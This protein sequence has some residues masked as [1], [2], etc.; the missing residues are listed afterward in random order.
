VTPIRME[1]P[2]VDPGLVPM[3]LVLPAPPMPSLSEPAVQPLVLVDAGEPL[4][5]VTGPGVT[6]LSAY[7][8]HG[9]PH[10]GEHLVARAGTVARLQEAAGLLPGRFGLVV[11]DAWRSLALQ[12]V[13]FEA[14]YS[15]PALPPGFVSVPLTDPRTPPPHL[16]GG[17]VDVTLS[18]QGMPLALGTGFDEFTPAAHTAHLEDGDDVRARDLRR[19]LV[20]VMRAAGFIA[21]RDEWWHFEYGTRRWAAITGMQP[22]YRAADATPAGD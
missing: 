21:Y 7:F 5:D 14:A 19:L 16:T 18:W 1:T 12:H 10:T 4:V 11:L 15:D 17:T 22:V 13:L 9:L 8:D 3:G 6:A 2:L 20:H